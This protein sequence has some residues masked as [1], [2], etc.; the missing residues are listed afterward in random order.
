MRVA[1]VGKLRQGNRQRAEKVV[2][3]SERIAP[4]RY[5]EKS[6]DLAH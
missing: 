2:E 5:D 1:H 4:K 3:D 6:R